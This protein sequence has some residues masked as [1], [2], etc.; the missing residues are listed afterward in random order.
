[1]APPIR[2]RMA[3]QF[4]SLP[5]LR[6]ISKRKCREMYGFGTKVPLLVRPVWSYNSRWGLFTTGCEVLAPILG[7]GSEGYAEPNG[8]ASSQARGFLALL[9]T[10]ARRL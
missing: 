7:F 9:A 3:P 6:R 10:R 4:L 1:M 2:A 8:D 5:H